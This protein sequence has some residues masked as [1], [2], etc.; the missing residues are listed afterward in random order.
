MP[1]LTT[2]LAVTVAGV[3]AGIA[4]SAGLEKAGPQGALAPLVL[5]FCVVLLRFPEACLGLL[6]FGTAMAEAEPVGAIPSGERFYDQVFSSFTAPDMLILFGLAGV[7]LR[8]VAQDLR[9]RLP[10]PLT[11]PL[12][13]LGLAAMAGAAT[14]FSTGSVSPPELFHR[15]MQIGHLILIPLLAVNVLR[16][17]RALK[18]FAFGLAIL[19]CLKGVTGLY[20][21]LGGF[22]GGVEEEVASFLNPFPNLLMLIFGL[23]V[24]AALVRRIQLPAWMLVGLPI[25]LLALLLSYRRSFWIAAI[26]TIVLVVIIASRRRGRAVFAIGAVTLALAF[27]ATNS[28]SGPADSTS[29]SPIAERAQTLTPSGIG[30]N[31]GDRYRVD[32]RSNVIENIERHPF[33]GVGLGVDWEVHRPLAEAHDRRY[34][35][36]AFLWYWLA[37]GILGAIAYLLLFGSALWTG[38]QI[39]RF[40]PD[41]TVQICAIAVFGGIVGLGV[42]ELTATF[43]GIEPRLTILLGSLL[44]WLAAAWQDV[45]G[46]RAAASP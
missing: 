26:L 24:I 10:N 46:R 36:F 44:G 17:T 3:L 15:G 2:G 21:S 8:F 31:R 12:I 4:F 20:A 13:L 39:W 11:A 18:I 1:A 33:T 41:P 32:E 34:V 43:T 9:P 22:G 35:H 27:V 25:T 40:H 30:S 23:G 6:L 28:I 5:L 45:P 37:L 14:A 16:D 29:P 19:A 42:V 38:R 7:L